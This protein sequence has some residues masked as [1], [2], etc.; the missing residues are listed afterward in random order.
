MQA[1]EGEVLTS[2]CDADPD[3]AVGKLRLV[4]VES[5]LEAIESLKLDVTKALGL[6]ILADKADAHSL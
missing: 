2:L 5:G 6:S 4:L 1:V 3:S